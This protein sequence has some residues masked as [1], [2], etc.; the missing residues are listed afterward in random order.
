MLRSSII[1]NVNKPAIIFSVLPFLDLYQYRSRLTS[2]KRQ[3]VSNIQSGPDDLTHILREEKSESVHSRKPFWCPQISRIVSPRIASILFSTLLARTSYQDDAYIPCH[4][5]S[6][7]RPVGC[8]QASVETRMGGSYDKF[9]SRYH[10]CR[11]R[12][13]KHITI[14]LLW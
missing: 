2:G 6:P 3:R 10:R 11:C 13:L 7:R 12:P 14:V 8:K 9:R 1:S 4:K 5:Q